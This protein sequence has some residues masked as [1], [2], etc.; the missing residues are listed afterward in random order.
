MPAKKK[1][2]RRYRP[3]VVYRRRSPNQS[4][5]NGAR[6]SLIVIHSTES[7]NI[8]GSQSDLRGVTDYLCRPEVK[9]SSQV[10]V[11]GDGNSARLV[12]D[13]AK[14][15][16]QA[17]YN[18]WALSIEQVGRAATENWT[19]DEIRETARWVARWS[20]KYGIPIR[21]AQVSNGRVVRSGVITHKRLGSLGGGHVDPGDRYPMQAMM[22]LARFYRARI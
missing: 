1:K 14:A 12:A 13:S 6:P 8:K 2:P 18:P 9:A 11:D 17:Y 20:K 15:W 16:T 4:S 19:R 7:S 10:I 5:R 22:R 3:N 21:R